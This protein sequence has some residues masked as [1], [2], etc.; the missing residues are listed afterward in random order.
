MRIEV[1]SGDGSL[2]RELQVYAEYRVFVALQQFAPHIDLVAVDARDSA[3]PR[4]SQGASC[5]VSVRLLPA[6]HV[7]LRSRGRHAAAAIDAA[8][9]QLARAIEAEMAEPA[10]EP[11]S[12]SGLDRRRTER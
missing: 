4:E 12:E 11:N 10:C 5:E 3:Q 8:A 2:T 7:L 6:G 1:H 9:S